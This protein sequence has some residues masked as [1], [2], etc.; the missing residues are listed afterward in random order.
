MDPAK[1][2]P[3][4]PAYKSA[5]SA[6]ISSGYSLWYQFFLSVGECHIIH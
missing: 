6:Y 1:D 5:H 3:T 4:F 2:A